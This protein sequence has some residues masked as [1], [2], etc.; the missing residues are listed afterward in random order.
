LEQRLADFEKRMDKNDP[1]QCKLLREMKSLTKDVNK[2][3]GA[4]EWNKPST[5]R[6]WNNYENSFQPKTKKPLEVDAYRAYLTHKMREG[7]NDKEDVLRLEDRV[8]ED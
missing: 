3:R 2:A 4:K 8:S 7:E 1:D 5:F 6:N